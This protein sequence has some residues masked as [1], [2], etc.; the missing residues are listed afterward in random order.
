MTTSRYEKYIV[1]KPDLPAHAGP[2][3]GIRSEGWVNS[4]SLVLCD[5]K[6]FKQAG[7][8]IEYGMIKGNRPPATDT[9][10]GP[11]S[12]KHDY[13]ELFAFIGTNPDDVYDLGAVCEMWL[14]EGEERE[15]VVFTTTS[16][17]YI[18]AGLA[19]LPQHWSDIKRP[20]IYLVIILDST[21]YVFNPASP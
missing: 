14:G 5:N 6:L 8:I 19:H 4:G 20:V 10:K 12:H 11:G 21:E 16:S 18:P 17:L 15:K 7:S 13:D 1:R 2:N 9:F 3:E